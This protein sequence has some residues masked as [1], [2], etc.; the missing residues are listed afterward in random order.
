[1][2]DLLMIISSV[3]LIIGSV[4]YGITW[5]EPKWLRSKSDL[6]HAFFASIML[7]LIA[8]SGHNLIG[9]GIYGLFFV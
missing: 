6:F 1:M 4:M 3:E 2:I 8:A 7:I 5:V 9:L